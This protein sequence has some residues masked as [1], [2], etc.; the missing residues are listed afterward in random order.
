MYSANLSILCAPPFWFLF[1]VSPLIKALHNLDNNNNYRGE[2]KLERPS[3]L[4]SSAL[5]Q[6]WAE[7]ESRS[8]SQPYDG[9][10][11]ALLYT[12]NIPCDPVMGRFLEMT[13]W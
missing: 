1:L 12:H 6:L 9:L 3:L 5:T 7:C 8:E 13:I 2:L 10:P 11:Q 4:S